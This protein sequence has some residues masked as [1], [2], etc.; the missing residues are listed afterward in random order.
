MMDTIHFVPT[1]YLCFQRCIV[2]I[3]DKHKNGSIHLFV[4]IIIHYNN[5][6]TK[7][8]NVKNF[9][10]RKQHNNCININKEL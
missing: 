4:R 10:G 1:I 9:H 8:K 7:K 6:L 3:A 5:Y 2:T